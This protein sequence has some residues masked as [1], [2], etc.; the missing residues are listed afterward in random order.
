MERL[1]Q[2]ELAGA[3]S[4]AAAGT[5]PVG[6][7]LGRQRRQ[8]RAAE[9]RDAAQQNTCGVA[10]EREARAAALGAQLRYERGHLLLGSLDHEGDFFRADGGRRQGAQVEHARDEGVR[11]RACERPPR[12]HEGGHRQAKRDAAGLTA[13]A[14]D[15]RA[16]PGARAHDQRPRR[17]LSLEPADRD[18]ALRNGDPQGLRELARRSAVVAHSQRGDRLC[19]PA[20][21]AGG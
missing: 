3:V 6:K 7:A 14:E 9:G 16:V 13:A 20:R 19:V 5:D 17:A 11:R 10:S 2:P 21:V 4:Q 18:G 8:R 15:G 12:E 1:S